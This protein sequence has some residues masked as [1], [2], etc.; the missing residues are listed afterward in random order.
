MIPLFSRRD[1]TASEAAKKENDYKFNYLAIILVAVII[2]IVF[3]IKYLVAT[4]SG[5]GHEANAVQTPAPPTVESMIK[6]G[7]FARCGL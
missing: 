1:C 3:G 6:G 4:F 7:G 2:G 5:P